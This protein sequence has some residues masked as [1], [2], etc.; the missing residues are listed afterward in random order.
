MRPRLTYANVIS[1]LALFLALGGVSYAVVSLPAN[2]VGS[3]QLKRSSVKGKHLKRGAVGPRKLKQDSVGERAVA[4][5]AIGRSELQSGAV[6]SEEIARFSIGTGELNHNSVGKRKLK[7]DSV[8]QRAV[9]PNAVGP[10]ELTPEAQPP[11]FAHISSS[12]VLGEAR[13]VESAGRISK[14]QYFAIFDRELRGCVAVAS[15][16]FGFGPGVIGAGGTAQA[17][18][19]LDNNPRKVGLT[20]YRK[21]W[22]FN[23][24]EDNDVNVIVAC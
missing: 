16:G 7:E 11:R 4:P 20:V 18:M 1:T 10:L 15:V 5:N 19:N 12:G 23:D 13:G 17:R 21:G 2:S 6:G 24:V 9:A 22:T 14:G 8:D 3:K